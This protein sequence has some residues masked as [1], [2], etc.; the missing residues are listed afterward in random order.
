MAV[1]E[2]AKLRYIVFFLM[3]FVGLTMLIQIAVLASSS[4]PE[5][6]ANMILMGIRGCRSVVARFHRW[7][8]H[9]FD[10]GRSLFLPHNQTVAE[11]AYRKFR[12]AG[13]FLRIRLK[14]ENEQ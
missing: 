4:R 10:Q 3:L 5:P 8:C 6:G 11:N 1:K 12:T 2:N 9:S 13:P 14:T 7:I